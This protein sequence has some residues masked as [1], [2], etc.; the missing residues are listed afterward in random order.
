MWLKNAGICILFISCNNI[1]SNSI[2]INYITSKDW[3]YS[4]GYRVTDFIKFDSTGYFR[5]TGDTLFVNGIAK[6]LIIA[7]DKKNFDLKISSLNR[8]ETGH[9]EDTEDMYH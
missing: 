9:Y 7:S 3:L 2:D 1:T 6:A 4:S 8:K 5:I